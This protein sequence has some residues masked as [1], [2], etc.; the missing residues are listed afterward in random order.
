MREVD[1]GSD[2]RAVHSRVL[3]HNQSALESGMARIDPWLLSIELRIN[4]L[5]HLGDLRLGIGVPSRVLS[6][7][8][9]DG[10]PRHGAEALQLSIHEVDLRLRRRPH[11]HRELQAVQI[12]RRADRARHRRLHEAL[13][14]RR[15]S[16]RPERA[17]VQEPH[18]PLRR[19][20]VARRPRVLHRLQRE[21]R[22]RL[23]ERVLVRER[24]ERRAQL[25]LHGVDR[26]GADGQARHAL[27]RDRVVRS[28]ALQREDTVGVRVGERREEAAEHVH[29]IGAAEVDVAARV[30]AHEVVQHQLARD[31]AFF[32][33]TH[34]GEAEL[35]VEAARAADADRVLVFVVHVDE[36]RGL[37]NARLQIAGAVQT[38][39]LVARDED[40]QGTVLDG[41]VSEDSEAGGNTD[42]IVSTQR[43][44]RGLQILAVNARNNRIFGEIDVN[45]VIC[46]ADHIHMALEAHRLLVLTTFE[47][48]LQG[49]RIPG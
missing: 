49:R 17:R 1:F 37:Q 29:R 9:R 12:L 43:G 19:L 46:L 7:A 38:G 30:T 4:L 21:A 35:H 24:R 2:G 3:L 42:A 47:I 6:D 36:R 32:D 13:H 45:F 41:L 14:H 10:H 23:D 34:R 26:R 20:L 48:T 11:R 31:E 27:A 25:R 18:Q 5:H 44:V 22:R 8:L 39:L 28:A 40:F 16:L 33:L 15:E